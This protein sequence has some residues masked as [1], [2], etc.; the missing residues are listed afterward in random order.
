M[1]LNYKGYYGALA[2]EPKDQI[3]YGHLIGIDTLVD[4]GGETQS[5][6][7]ASFREAVDDYLAFC[8]DEG[9][10]PVVPDMKEWSVPVSFRPYAMLTS[11]AEESGKPLQNVVDQWLDIYASGIGAVGQ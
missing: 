9:R 5:E 1:P 7:T 2:W 10:E 11:E 8:E 3:Y 6:A 4:Y